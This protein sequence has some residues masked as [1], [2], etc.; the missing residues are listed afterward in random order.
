MAD[1]GERIEDTTLQAISEVIEP[2]FVTEEEGVAHLVVFKPSLAGSMVGHTHVI[3]DRVV[4]GRSPDADIQ[5]QTTDV[6]REHATITQV[7]RGRFVLK[8]LGSS[9]GTLVNNEPVQEIALV[10]GDRVKIG[11][12]SLLIFTR[13]HPLE[14]QLIQSQKLESLGRLAAGIAHE[15]NNPLTYVYY[16]LE[17]L[18]R[19]TSKIAREVIDMLS[20]ASEVRRR[21][22]LADDPE[23]T[24]LIGATEEAVDPDTLEG[25]SDCLADAKD[26]VRRIRAIVGDLK[27]FSRT[28]EEKLVPVDVNEV[29]ESTLKMAGNQI[30]FRARLATEFGDNPPVLAN[31]GRLTQVFLNL[32][33]NAAQS[34]TRGSRDENTIAVRTWTVNDEVLARVQDTGEG[35]SAEDLKSI[36]EPFFSTKGRSGAGLGL[37]IC[38][39][40]IATL[41]GRID[42]DSS[43][44]VGTTF[45]VRLP[46]TQILRD[47]PVT[48]ETGR[49][50]AATQRQGRILVVD[51]EVGIGVAIRRMLLDHHEV[52]AACSAAEAQAI[53]KR[54][55]AFDLILCD[56]LM[57]EM[58]GIELF[59][60]IVEFDPRMA[61]KVI[62]MTGGAFTPEAMAF[63]REAPNPVLE[64][65][66]ELETLLSL[67]REDR[68]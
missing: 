13:Y 28:E 61:R 6:S 50:V 31:E 26:G 45:T 12:R 49:A 23:L 54:D 36:F 65:P 16:N 10:P 5:L 33:L 1:K 21:L 14:T 35:I 29:I 18:T 8:D 11:T 48:V 2:E 3:R 56:L 63:T 27:H 64:K 58:N 20:A 66:L 22:D 38:H 17:A 62:F 60:W 41:G 57:P 53:L 59:Q 30:K 68:G 32:L 46:K 52:Q 39:S 67:M 47:R 40:I 15:I 4:I 34:I 55:N 44:G 43:P 19:V 25:I 9:N 37:S 24:R 7:S 42:V 51:D